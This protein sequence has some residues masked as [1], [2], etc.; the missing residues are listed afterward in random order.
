[1]SLDDI[2]GIVKEFADGPEPTYEGGNGSIY[3]IY[4]DYDGPKAGNGHED[5]CLWIRA[6]KEAKNIMERI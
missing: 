3:C 2:L 1:M 4:C 6:K 5:D